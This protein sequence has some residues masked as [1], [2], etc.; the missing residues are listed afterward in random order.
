MSSPRAQPNR[1]L[2]SL[3]LA[4]LSSAS[5]TCLNCQPA[6]RLLQQSAWGCN[7]ASAHP[8]SPKKGAGQLQISPETDPYSIFQPS[9]PPGSLADGEGGLGTQGTHLCGS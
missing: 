6:R 1:H 2:F 4:L 8:T 3:F 7:T 5:S 9:L